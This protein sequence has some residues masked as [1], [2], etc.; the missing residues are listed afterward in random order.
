MRVGRQEREG[1]ECEREREG[2][3]ESG[4]ERESGALLQKCCITYV[5]IFCAYTERLLIMWSV[6][7]SDNSRFQFLLYLYSLYDHYV[8][9]CL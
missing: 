3:G 2:E 8:L 5:C 9:L 6:V 4:S 1:G 7:V